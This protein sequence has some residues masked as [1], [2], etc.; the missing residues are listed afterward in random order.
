MLQELARGLH[1]SDGPAR[2]QLET[3]KR[4]TPAPLPADVLA[5]AT[6]A[7]RAEQ[8]G[9]RQGAAAGSGADTVRPRGSLAAS[10]VGLAS[11]CTCRSS[12]ARHIAH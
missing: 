9:Q 11:V 1:V 5:A 6:A 3:H 12:I 10:Q 7:V 4:P 2:K 8:V